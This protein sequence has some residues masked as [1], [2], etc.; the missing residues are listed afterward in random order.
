MRLSP[1]TAQALSPPGSAGPPSPKALTASTLWQVWVDGCVEHHRT[2]LER[3]TDKQ[4]GQLRDLINIAHGRGLDPVTFV[5]TI[6]ADWTWLTRRVNEK[7]DDVRYI[8]DKPCLGFTRYFLADLISVVQEEAA[9][10]VKEAKR[11]A[12]RVA[13]RKAQREKEEAEHK[14]ARVAHECAERAKLDAMAKQGAQF[15]TRDAAVAAMYACIGSGD[16]IQSVTGESI[17]AFLSSWGGDERLDDKAICKKYRLDLAQGFWDYG[18]AETA[19]GEEQRL[20][21]GNIEPFP[22]AA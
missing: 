7:T 22:K 3:M 2:K 16:P 18:E 17:R 10:T 11:D 14:A 1:K 4:K 21:S 15:A 20:I 9:R 6:V 5:T 8:P 13:E 12:E 19:G